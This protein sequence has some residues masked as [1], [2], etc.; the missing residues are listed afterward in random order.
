[1]K[2]YLTMV[3]AIAISGIFVGC[4]EEEISGSLIEQKKIAFED[5][6]ITAFGQP[7]PTHNWGFLTPSTATNEAITRVADPRGNMWADEGW[8]VP[9]VINDAQKDIVRRYFQQNTPIGY[10]DPGWSDFWIQQVYKGGTNTNN[11]SKTTEKY[12]IGN[13]DEVTGGNHMDHLC[14]KS[15]NGTED[16]VNDFNN[17]D[18]NDWEG[19]MLMRSS[20]TY[21][22]G[23]INSNATAIH[24]DKAALVNWRVI[25]Q[26]AV[27]NGLESSVEESVLNDGW[28]RSYMGFDWE[29]ALPDDCY[30]PIYDYNAGWS[31]DLPGG[32]PILGYQTFEFDGKTYRLLSANSNQYAY[33]EN[34]PKYHGIQNYNDKPSDDIIRELLSLGY[35]PYSDTLKDWIKLSTGADGYYSDWIVTLTRAT[36]DTPQ[37]KKVSE[38]SAG[39]YRIYQTVLE[40]GRVMCEDL[41]GS[42]TLDDLDYNDVVFDAI[43]VHEYMKTT[44][45]QGNPTGNPYGD[46]YYVIVRLMAAGGTIPATLT[47]EGKTFNIHSVLNDP[48][49]GYIMINT[50]PEEERKDVNMAEVMSTDP[51]T[52]SY[53]DED[54]NISEKFYSENNQQISLKNIKIDVLYDRVSTELS[55][56]DKIAPLKFLTPLGTAWAKERKRIDSAYPGFPDWVKDKSKYVWENNNVPKGNGYLAENLEGLKESDITP[57]SRVFEGSSGSATKETVDAESTMAYP[58]M[59]DVILYSFAADNSSPGFLCPQVGSQS[60][61]LLTVSIPVD[62]QTNLEVGKTIRIYGVYIPGWYVTTT[63]ITGNTEYTQFDGTGNFIEI[64]LTNEIINIIKRNSGFTIRGKH[65]T[66]TYVTIHSNSSDNG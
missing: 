5:A 30:R 28:N 64:P 39:Y 55:N 33:D 53:T 17:S 29:Q 7:D 58:S 11:G 6:F 63:D 21:S 31:A 62:K 20:S 56:D 18:N 60:E 40:S 66:V 51:V 24:Y 50:L 52:L 41:A 35:L 49:T 23:Y 4:H 59:T 9:P 15:A 34:E 27:D 1:M 54:G 3:L 37:V 14:S 46:R 57:V 12:T 48:T 2:K 19:R 26:W 8:R 22:F 47:V 10:N 45:A 43:S 65:F 36:T 61:E 44:D 16:H 25:A 32:F 38:T 13:G 42:V